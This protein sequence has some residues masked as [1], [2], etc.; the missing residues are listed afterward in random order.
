M[1]KNLICC[2]TKTSFSKNQ[3]CNVCIGLHCH[4]KELRMHNKQVLAKMW[5]KGITF[6]LLVGM[7]TGAATVKSSTELPQKD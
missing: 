4:L 1:F 3:Q 2:K 6:A 5:R 7:Q